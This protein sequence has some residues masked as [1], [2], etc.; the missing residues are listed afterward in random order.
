M[1]QFPFI[2][3]PVFL[4]LSCNNIAQNK[5]STT[6][7]SKKVNNPYYSR[8]DTAKVNVAEKEWNKLLSP[9][10]YEVARQK[11]TELPFTGIYNKHKDVGTYYCTACGNPLFA[12]N[13]KFESNCGWPSFF[14]PITKGSIIYTPDNT[15]GMQRTEVTCGRCKSH[16]GHVFDDGPPPTGLRYCINSVSLDFEAAKK[17]RDQSNQ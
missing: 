12:S 17:A 7:N 13:G 8:E 6:M 2:L 14:E 3:L 4:M 11:G 1:K 16:L 9:K 10:V 5:T 15:H